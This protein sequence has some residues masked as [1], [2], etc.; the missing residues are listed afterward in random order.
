MKAFVDTSAWIALLVPS[1]KW[2]GDASS[3]FERILQRNT[4]SV[5][6]NYI[7]DETITWLRMRAGHGAAVE[8]RSIIDEAIAKRTLHLAWVNEKTDAHAW[9]L[10]TGHPGL[11]LSMTDCTSAVIAAELGAP[12]WSYDSDFAAL[13]C[14]VFTA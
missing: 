12:I 6:S 8:F 1:D 13:G 3:V 11:K 10:F 9:K 5:T 2:H 14:D 4:L 7:C